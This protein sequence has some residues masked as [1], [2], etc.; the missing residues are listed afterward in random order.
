MIRRPPR[1]T[2]FPYTTLFRSDVGVGHR[3]EQAAVNASLLGQL[4][5]YTVELFA[6]LL[7]SSQLFSRL[8]FQFDALGFELGLGGSR[9]TTGSAR[10]DQ[11]VAGVAVFDLDDVAEATE[12]HNLVEQ[13]DLHGCIP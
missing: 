6:Q 3:A 8:L 13:N 5:V 11:E 12:V 10:G 1:S 9:G 2:L 4:D 7:S